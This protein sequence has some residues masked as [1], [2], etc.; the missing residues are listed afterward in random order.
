[1][2]PR[3][4]FHASRVASSSSSHGSFLRIFS[5]PLRHPNVGYHNECIPSIRTSIITIYAII[6]SAYAGSIARQPSRHRTSYPMPACDIFQDPSADA[7]LQ[8][9]MSIN[10]TSRICAF[11][12]SFS[13]SI[14]SCTAAPVLMA[15]P[16]STSA[17]ARRVLLST[18][19]FCL[20]SLRL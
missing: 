14:F 6:H 13:V 5:R 3:H 16:T 4:Q 20:A 19:L 9:Q 15:P 8:R 2:N 18:A 7:M 10:Y 12:I 17:S 11:S 1:M